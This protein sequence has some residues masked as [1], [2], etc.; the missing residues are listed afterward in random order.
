MP[1]NSGHFNSLRCL[2]SRLLIVSSNLENDGRLAL[3]IAVLFSGIS[4]EPVL[5]QNGPTPFKCKDEEDDN[6]FCSQG[7]WWYGISTA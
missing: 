5:S 1:I 4:V 7:S 3:F 6:K 2:G